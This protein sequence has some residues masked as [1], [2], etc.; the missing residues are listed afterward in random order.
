MGEHADLQTLLAWWSGELDEPSADD[1]EEHLFACAACTRRAEALAAIADAMT[2][3]EPAAL[4]TGV[5]TPAI[6]AR[7]E[8]DGVSLQRFRVA[9]GG[10]T[11]CAVASRSELL[12]TELELP[13]E[14]AEALD[15]VI[16]APDGSVVH[17]VVD[18]PLAREAGVAVVAAPAGM[19]LTTPAGVQFRFSLVRT[20]AKPEEPALAHYTLEH[21]GVLAE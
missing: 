9:P 12:I 11:P 3:L 5:V 6:V 13:D 7:L 1:V 21:E 10:S 18:V 4:A 2:E 19:F 14:D 17:R 20:A 16:Y 15:L 8:A